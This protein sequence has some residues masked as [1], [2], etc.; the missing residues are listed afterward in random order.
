MKWTEMPVKWNA[1]EERK[2]INERKLELSEWNEIRTNTYKYDVK[3]IKK[4]EKAKG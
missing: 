1:N 2:R 3:L 4:K